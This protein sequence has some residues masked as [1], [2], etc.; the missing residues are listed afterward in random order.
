MSVCGKNC[1]IVGVERKSVA[2]L[3]EPRTV[4]KIFQLDN[5]VLL[6]FAGKFFKDVMFSHVNLFIIFN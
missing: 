3:Q 6:A 5:H 1:V 2:K 4:R